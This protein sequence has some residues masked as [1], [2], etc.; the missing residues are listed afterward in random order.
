MFSA[1]LSD[2]GEQFSAI[3]QRNGSDP[4]TT[5]LA[6]SSNVRIDD[7]AYSDPDRKSVVQG[8]I[9]ELNEVS[10]MIDSSGST[11]AETI[12]FST[13][14]GTASYGEGDYTT[15]SGGQPLNISSR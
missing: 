2:S 4:I 5:F 3:V 13:V 7:V 11:P 14:A 12:Y 9:V 15:T 10:F 8:K 6:K 1:G